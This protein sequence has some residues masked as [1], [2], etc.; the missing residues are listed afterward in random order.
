MTFGF[1]VFPNHHDKL[2]VTQNEASKTD[3]CYA[4]AIFRLPFGSRIP[5]RHRDICFGKLSL[6]IGQGLAVCKGCQ[7]S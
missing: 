7:S 6:P 4:V 1:S 2:S 3:K 5:S